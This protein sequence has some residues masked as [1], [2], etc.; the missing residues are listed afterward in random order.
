NGPA[1]EIALNRLAPRRL[2]ED[3]LVLRLHA[4]G[5]R[6]H[7]ER[8]RQADDGRNHGARTLVL[9][10]AADERLVDL[11]LVEGEID[12]VAE[13]RI[14]GAEIVHGDRNADLGKLV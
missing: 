14:A 5:D 8:P 11:Q 1:V 12:Q 6:V 10:H 3:D 4:F 9:L 7:A 2:Q 13:V